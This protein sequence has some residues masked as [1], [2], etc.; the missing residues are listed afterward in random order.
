MERATLPARAA[1]DNHRA[2]PSGQGAGHVEIVDTVEAQLDEVGVFDAVA[3]TPE[4][5]GRARRHGYNKQWPSGHRGYKKK[6]LHPLWAEEARISPLDGSQAIAVAPSAEPQYHHT[7]TPGFTRG[8]A[9]RLKGCSRSM[10]TLRT[11]SK[12]RRLCQPIF[13]FL[14]DL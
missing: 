8:S 7:R 9:T 10:L 11:I 14:L 3:P 6:P 4:V 2:C 13:P 12:R 1:G 5:G